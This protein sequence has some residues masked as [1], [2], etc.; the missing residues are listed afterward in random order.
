M[1]VMAR[2]TPEVAFPY[3]IHGLQPKRAERLWQAAVWATDRFDYSGEGGQHRVE[4]TLSADTVCVF[5]VEY[6][7]A[8]LEAFDAKGV[9]LFRFCTSYWERWS[10]KWKLD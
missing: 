4:I 3:K 8:Y 5:G 1:C 2:Y 10:E 6:L 9:N 7:G